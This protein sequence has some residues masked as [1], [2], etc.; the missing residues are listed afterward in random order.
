MTS[1]ALNALAD[2][3]EAGSGPDRELDAAVWCALLHPMQK[4]QR[5]FFYTAREEW[6]FFTTNQPLPGLTFHEAP[7]LATDLT[8]VVSLIERVLPPGTNWTLHGTSGPGA[9]YSAHLMQ[10][11]GY[12][13]SPERALTAAL[14]RAAAAQIGEG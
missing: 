10:Q 4:P 1:T 2:R 8:A 3:V 13:W 12:A 6:G 14:L 9:S 11:S 7:P 5:N